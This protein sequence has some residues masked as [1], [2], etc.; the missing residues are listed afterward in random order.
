MEEKQKL[1]SH[2]GFGKVLTAPLFILTGLLLFARNMGIITEEWF[3][4]LVAW[5]SLFIITGIYSMIRRHYL[6]GGIL[7]PIGLYLL[8]SRFM[9]R[10]ISKP[11]SGRWFL[12]SS[13]FPFSDITIEHATSYSTNFSREQHTHLLRPTIDLRHTN[14]APGETGLQLGRSTQCA[15]FP[16]PPFIKGKGNKS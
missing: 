4:M 12:S 9:S 11:Y 14:I 7:L 15:T 13:A 1:P 2:A 16:T 5:H 8:G 10:A 6:S 3:N